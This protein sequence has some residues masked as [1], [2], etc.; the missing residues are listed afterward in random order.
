MPRAANGHYNS[1][2]ASQRKRKRKKQT[3][4]KESKAEVFAVMA[5]QAGMAFDPERLERGFGCI[6][7]RYEWAFRSIR[8]LI[9]W[10]VL[11]LL[12]M[13]SQMRWFHGQ[14]EPRELLEKRRAT[15]REKAETSHQADLLYARQRGLL[16]WIPESV[17]DDFECPFTGN[18][19]DKRKLLSVGD[20]T[21]DGHDSLVIYRTG[22]H[23][24][25]YIAKEVWDGSVDCDGRR[26]GV[27]IQAPEYG[28]RSVTRKLGGQT[29]GIPYRGTPGYSGQPGKPAIRAEQAPR[30]SPVG[31]EMIITTKVGFHS[32]SEARNQAMIMVLRKGVL[33]PEYVNLRRA[34]R[35]SGGAPEPQIVVGTPPRHNVP[36]D[37]HFVTPK[38]QNRDLGDGQVILPNIPVPLE[39]AVEQGLVSAT[40]PIHQT[41]GHTS[42]TLKPVSLRRKRRRKRKKEADSPDIREMV[43]ASTKLAKKEQEEKQVKLAI[44]CDLVTLLSE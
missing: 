32:E 6:L 36:V 8:N 2:G 43:S 42:R 34:S 44:V 12:R 31:D 39:I 30:P 24:K 29:P 16:Q 28:E 41:A 35:L 13:G 23:G 7:S 21:G 11:K 18:A 1:S 40:M 20:P 26:L 4:E 3:L 27:D 15:V 17:P 33:G 14:I 38:E 5:E 22:N 19:A 9:P 10:E 25:W 37:R